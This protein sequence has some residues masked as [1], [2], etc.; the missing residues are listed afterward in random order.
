[1]NTGFLLDISWATWAWEIF[2]KIVYFLEKESYEQKPLE[3]IEQEENYLEITNPLS[4]EIYKIDN[5]IDINSQQIKLN[6]STNIKH[7]NHIWFVDWKELKKD[8]WSLEK[9]AHEVLIKLYLDW[10]MVS[11][12]KNKIKVE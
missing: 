8:F 1:M 6:Y 12:V 3:L 2:R 9:W 4:W 7:N 5:N 10:T 11:E